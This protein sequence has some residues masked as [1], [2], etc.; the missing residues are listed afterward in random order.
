MELVLESP[1]PPLVLGA[2]VLEVLALEVLG[3]E[4]LALE[5]LGLAL[6]AQALEPVALGLEVQVLELAALGLGQALGLEL[7]LAQVPEEEVNSQTSYSDHF[8]QH[9]VSI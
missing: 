7:V 5:A 1:P 6:E 8:G 4:A 3:L 9:D 2:L